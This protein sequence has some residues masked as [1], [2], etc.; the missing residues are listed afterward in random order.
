MSSS[1][2]SLSPAELA[3]SVLEVL[4]ERGEPLT[5]AQVR[6]RLRRFRPSPEDVRRSLEELV[7]QGKA[8]AWPAYRSK[9]PRYAVRT[10]DEAARHTLTRLLGEMAFTRAELLSAL[11]REVP[12][13]E[14]ERCVA[15]MDAVLAEGTVRKLPPRVGSN[16]HLLGTPHPRAYLGPVFSALCKS[17]ARLVNRL[18]T[19]GV[20]SE[21]VF[22]VAQ[23]MWEETLEEAR[24]EVGDRGS[25]AQSTPAAAG[26]PQA[27]SAPAQPTLFE[28]NE[29]QQ[30]LDAL[31][32]PGETI[33]LRELRTRLH[34]SFPD[35]SQLDELLLRL[36][37]E[38]RIELRPAQNSESSTEE[39]LTGPDGQ[40]FDRVARRQ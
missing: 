40:R 36:S 22:R 14:D 15:A 17:L 38:G 29:T 35:R 19:E 10:M 4:T 37:R 21:Q 16:S 39:V 6:E 20:S 7:A 2:A 12:G 24:S 1:V 13:L 9:T 27:A 5:E 34:G 32:A 31:P 26:Q 18:E 28:A 30:L 33:A 3:T 8:H 11:R 25:A 23:V